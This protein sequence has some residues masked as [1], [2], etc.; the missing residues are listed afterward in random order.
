[1]NISFGLAMCQLR[2]CIG[3]II[4]IE[5][6]KIFFAQYQPDPSPYDSQSV[7][8]EEQDFASPYKQCNVTCWKF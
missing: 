3:I 6:T 8:F 1:M 5:Q 2:K 7:A 4:L